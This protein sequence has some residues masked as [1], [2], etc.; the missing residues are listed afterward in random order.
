[1][2]NNKPLL[3]TLLIILASLQF[4]WLPWYEAQQST[5]DEAS[6]LTAKLAKHEAVQGAADNIVQSLSQI[7]TAYEQQMD[8]LL[9]GEDEQSFSIEIQQKISEKIAAFNLQ[10]DF[11]TWSGQASIADTS[12]ARGQFT[13]RVTGTLV[14]V[15]KFASQLEQ[16]TGLRIVSMHFDWNG[17]AAP[18]KKTNTTFNIEI[19]YRMGSS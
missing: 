1:M 15:A 12:V 13:V 10:M 16:Q 4:I 7:K 19:L 17:F 5:I 11:F 3:Y 8:L 9:L 2:L 18:D 6:V 14:D